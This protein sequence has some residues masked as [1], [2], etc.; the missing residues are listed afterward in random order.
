MPRFHVVLFDPATKE[1]QGCIV[2]CISA[3]EAICFHPWLTSVYLP[4]YIAANIYDGDVEVVAENLYEELGW[5]VLC[6]DL[7]EAIMNALNAGGLSV[8]SPML[9]A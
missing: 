4:S 5:V 1:K 3:S 6:V 7:D 9:P 8:S 2:S